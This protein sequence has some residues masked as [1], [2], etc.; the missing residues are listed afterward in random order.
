[1]GL[2]RIKMFGK[3]IAIKQITGKNPL[4]KP[5]CHGVLNMAVMEFEAGSL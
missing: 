1:M 2:F 3:I 5:F 4:Q